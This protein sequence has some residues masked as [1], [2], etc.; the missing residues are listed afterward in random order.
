[1]T[2]RTVQAVGALIHERQPDVVVVQGDTTSAFCA[3]L[4]A[5]YAKVPVVHLEAGLRTGD[6][7]SPFPEEV[8]RRLISQFAALHLAPTSTSRDEPAA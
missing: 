3:G 4:A 7:Y 2:A 5:F 8:N 1:M 6:I